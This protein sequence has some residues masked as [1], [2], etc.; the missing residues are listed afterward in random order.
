VKLPPLT[1]PDL[2]HFFEMNNR[3]SNDQPPDRMMFVHSRLDELGLTPAQFRVY[4][5][6]SRRADKSG[7][8]WPAVANIARVCRLHPKTV[9]A[10]LRALIGRSMIVPTFRAGETTC[11]NLTSHSEWRPFF[12]GGGND[13][14]TDTA[15]SE[16]PGRPAKRIQPHHSQND[17]DKGNPSEGNQLKEI[18]PPIVPQRGT[19]ART[20]VKVL[21]AQVN[22]IYAAFPK[23][24][25]KPAALRAI[26][27]AVATNGS[28]HVLQRTRLFAK[29]YN[30][31]ARFI[32]NPARWFSEERFHDD[33]ATWNRAD[34]L[35][36]SPRGK[37][38]PPRQ[39]DRNDYKQPPGSL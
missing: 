25:G 10:A 1:E 9:R 29:T 13:A 8:A 33:P 11:Y 17:A 24:V 36:H 7:V 18:Q 6:L 34:L 5:H 38:A 30:G 37:V 23:Q 16:A 28:D 35:H 39:F 22:E 26:R 32:P 12:C 27:K 15:H 31:Q 21:D 3:Q 4:G 14:Q 2:A 20:D 19:S